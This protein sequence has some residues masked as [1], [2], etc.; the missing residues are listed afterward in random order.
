MRLSTLRAIN[1]RCFDDITINCG[2]MHA[3]VGANCAGKSTVA[4]ALDFLFNASAAKVTPDWFNHRKTKLE[5]RV[6]GL[7]IDLTKGELEA[8]KGYLR[9]DHSFHLARTAKWVGEGDDATA[10]IGQSYNKPQPRLA[11]LNPEKIDG[12]SVRQW[13]REELIAN[14]HSFN[15]FISGEKVTVGMWKEKAAAFAAQ[16]LTK[17][18]YAET[19]ADNPKGF[20][21]V[22]KGNLPHF[23]LIPAV[24]DIADEGKVG[25]TNPFGKLIHSILEKLDPGLKEEMEAA[26]AATTKKLNRA[27]GDE[28]IKAISDMEK[29][30]REYVREIIPAD[31]ELEFEP[32]TV[33]T[34]LTSP[35]MIVDD[36]FRGPVELMGHGLQRAII[37]SILR[38]YA[39]LATARELGRRRTLILGVEEPELYMHPPMLRSIRKVLRRIADGGDQVFFTT[40]N[41]I[42]VDVGFFDEIV[43]VE[44]SP[45]G[46]GAKVHQ[47]SMSAMIEDLE[48]RRPNL[49]G[50][51][52]PDSMRERYSHVYT[53][54]RNEGFFA[55][56]VILVEGQTEFYCLP[57]YAVPLGYDFDAMGV[58]VVECGTKDQI[59]RLYRVFNEL[60]TPCYVLFDYDL[61]TE[62]EKNSE[63][64]L[65]HLDQAYEKPAVAMDGE[66]VAFFKNDWEVDL[67]PEIPEYEK[68][69][70]EATK[71]LGLRSD[72]GKPLKARYI[73][74]KL[75]MSDKPY[76]PPTIEKIIRKAVDVKHT[77]TC[78]FAGPSVGR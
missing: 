22:L 60:G 57:I 63:E 49:K 43:R 35:T 40:H 50:K 53:T 62:S 39:D 54:S 64:L 16:Y 28:R 25:K 55:K 72:S 31:V 2:S 23:E 21:G 73:A 1:F 14:G 33:E 77:V 56:K 68:L 6:E 46:N 13:S 42:L 9:E 7:F 37:M 38:A 75:T 5:L 12:D 44:S 10:E 32:P 15:E 29:R 27:A 48:L 52:T 11:W 17:P 18:D 19:W 24:R 3:L 69:A 41:P 34:I 65:R 20:T 76:V 67:M 70:G 74:Q 51:V 45:N 30:L 71:T 47:L 66:K 58:V 8:F 26:L 36:G 4:H 78:L 59:D 61:G